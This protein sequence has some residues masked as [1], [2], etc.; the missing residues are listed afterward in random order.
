MDTRESIDLRMICYFP[1]HTPN[2]CPEIGTVP[3][4][5]ECAQLLATKVI[6]RMAGMVHLNIGK[7]PGHKTEWVVERV[8]DGGADG[9]EEVI[10]NAVADEEGVFELSDKS[11]TFRNMVA[12]VLRENNRFEKTLKQSISQIKDW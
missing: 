4:D 3:T 7:W 6:I 10:Q 5:E 12:S 8:R 9:L 1:D 2:T 11:D